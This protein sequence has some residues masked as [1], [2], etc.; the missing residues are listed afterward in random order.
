MPYLPNICLLYA[1]A[2]YQMSYKPADIA[3]LTQ[4]VFLAIVGLVFEQT[5]SSSRME[6]M[7]DC[8]KGPQCQEREEMCFAK[9]T[10]IPERAPHG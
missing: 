10:T 5:S 3:P 7:D 6:A 1:G 8:T 9:M 4:R 2:S